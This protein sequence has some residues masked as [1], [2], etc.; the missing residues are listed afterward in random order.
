M[1]STLHVISHLV[2]TKN[3]FIIHNFLRLIKVIASCSSHKAEF[4]SWS[5]SVQAHALLISCDL[6]FNFSLK[7]MKCGWIVKVWESWLGQVTSVSFLSH[8][9]MKCQEQIC[10]Q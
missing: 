3:T 2:L 1:P 9:T 5:A 8:K 6:V 7:F 4:E 10:P